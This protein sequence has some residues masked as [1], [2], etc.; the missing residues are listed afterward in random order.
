MPSIVS[1]VTTTM[2]PPTQV[3]C[4]TG[5][6]HHHQHR[7][8]SW[9]RVLESLTTSYYSVYENV[10]EWK[11]GSGLETTSNVKPDVTIQVCDQDEGVRMREFLHQNVSNC[12]GC[13]CF[14]F[15]EMITC[16]PGKMRWKRAVC[17]GTVRGGRLLV[18]G[19]EIRA[20][21]E[22]VSSAPGQ[23]V[24]LHHLSG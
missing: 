5:R 8:V 23:E 10:K 4:N 24:S 22:G 21:W 15:D 18:C 9:C 1:M 6:P 16:N 3:N 2:Q 12:R 17:G 14:F 19:S 13:L 20:R 11:Q 7:A